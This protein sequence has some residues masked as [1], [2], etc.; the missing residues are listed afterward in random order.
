VRNIHENCQFFKDFEI[1]NDYLILKRFQRTRTESSLSLESL[2]NQNQQFFKN[3]KGCTTLVHT[4][5]SQHPTQHPPYYLG[6]G[7]C[8]V[9]PPPHGFGP[10][11][12][13]ILGSITT[14]AIGA[15]PG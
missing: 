2:K 3:S 13:G 7:S 11:W 6:A 10:R 4:P 8:V 15:H 1:T 12:L 14:P 9:R 5:Y